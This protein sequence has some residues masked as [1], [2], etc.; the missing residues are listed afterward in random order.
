MDGRLRT[1][2]GLTGTSGAAIEVENLRRIYEIRG[3]DPITALDGVSFS[4]EAGTIVALLG[5]NGAG[6]TT[7]VKILSTV[8]LPTGGTARV[9]GHDVVREATTVRRRIGIVFGGERGLYDRL[10]A[11]ENIR[12]WAVLYG[13]GS[14]AA[15]SRADELLELVGLRDL[16]NARVET[17]SRGMKQRVHLARGLVGEGRALFLDEPSLGMDPVAAHEFRRLAR[18][19]RDEGR[20]LLLATHDLAEA[21]AIS[22]RV[23]LIDRGRIL[24]DES[25]ASL[26]ERTRGIEYIETAVLEADVERQ[27]RSI[28]GV[29]RLGR[30]DDNGSWRIEAASHEAARAV[31]AVLLAAGVSTL[32]TSG[33]SLDD[34]Y[35]D[36]IGPRGMQA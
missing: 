35:L 1:T 11:R 17:F 22:D 34:V 8:L 13:L 9:L 10:T 16:A 26:A 15:A 2:S 19:L 30:R 24:L 32:T 21:S 33:P 28:D 31:V 36:L 3:R 18:R 4:A 5:P 7:L 14:S 12:H 29:A 23:L 6:K 27:V 25:P 20:T